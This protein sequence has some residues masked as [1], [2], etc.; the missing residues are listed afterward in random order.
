MS[1]NIKTNADGEDSL[2][3]EYIDI[4]DILNIDISP[5]SE[6]VIKNFLNIK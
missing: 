1:N 3:A 4:E 5:I 2:G 6:L